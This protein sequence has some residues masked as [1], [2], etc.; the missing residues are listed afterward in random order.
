MLL[1][2]NDQTYII[3]EGTPFIIKKN[4]EEKRFNVLESKGDIEQCGFCVLNYI[5][6]N[7][8]QKSKF[9]QRFLNRQ[10]NLY[11][12]EGFKSLRVLQSDEEPY[13]IILTLWN[14]REAFSN[15][16]SSEQYHKTHEK[17]GTS[18]G[19]DQSVI[20]REKSFNVRFD[21]CDQ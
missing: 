15:W 16:Q 11:H 7:D 10:S 5:Y 3:E 2:N 8:G 1:K 4:N 14:D 19:M 9:E 12:V 17:R 13:Y 20:N 21:L 18:Q 6:I